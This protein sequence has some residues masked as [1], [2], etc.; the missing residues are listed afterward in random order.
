MRVLISCAVAS[1]LGSVTAPSKLAAPAKEV[2]VATDVNVEISG[3]SGLTV[4]KDGDSVS[5][6][7]TDCKDAA[8]GVMAPELTGSKT[9][10]KAT[11]K[12]SKMGTYKVCYKLK[13][14]AEYTAVDGAS[15]VVGNQW[16]SKKVVHMTCSNDFEDAPNKSEM[17]CKGKCDAEDHVT[18]CKAKHP[19]LC[20]TMICPSGMHQNPDAAKKQCKTLPCAPDLKEDQD[21]CCAKNQMCKDVCTGDFVTAE[22]KEKVSCLGAKCSDEEKKT[23][24][25]KKAACTKDICPAKSTLKPKAGTCAGA[26]CTEKADA[27]TCCTV[28]ATCSKDACG[29]G[30]VLKTDKSLKC[31]ADKCTTA[32]DQATCC[33]KQAVCSVDVCGDKT[34]IKK[35]AV[36][37]GATCDK[38]KDKAACC[39]A[40]A[41]C[42]AS[43]CA[44]DKVL[45]AKAMCKGLKCD[46]AVDAGTCCAA[47]A[48]CSTVK[49]LT[50]QKPA[51]ALCK[52]EK[53]VNADFKI[54]CPLTTNTCGTFIC[55]VNLVQDPAKKAVTCEG[56]ECLAP[57]D[58]AK[59]CKA[60]PH[61]SNKALTQTAK[62]LNS[63][64]LA[65]AFS[66][67]L[68]PLLT[69]AVKV[70]SQKS[71]PAKSMAGDIAL[72]F[73]GG[74]AKQFATALARHPNAVTSAM[75][76][77][78]ADVAGCDDDDIVLS[79]LK[80]AADA[81]RLLDERRLTPDQNLHFCMRGCPT[82]LPPTWVPLVCFLAGG[83]IAAVLA[84]IAFAGEDSGKGNEG[85]RSMPLTQSTQMQQ[86][87]PAGQ[88]YTTSGQP[89][90]TS[91]QTYTVVGQ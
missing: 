51:D 23:C 53:C 50:G 65:A 36:C 27:E 4:G 74:D 89:Y 62:S 33:D 31:K 32:T 38:A 35:D 28:P 9:T 30:F 77:A 57:R 5:F 64:S 91:G 18:C 42:E 12:F 90:V 3:G 41:K 81:R 34:L 2:E 8:K 61:P 72:D 40:P 71:D 44:K 85:A 21:T 10:A 66:K 47:K 43:L 29:T 60:A 70:V 84:L 11:V 25:A 75:K 7:T 87:A 19:A 49:C 76:M 14:K 86:Y 73:E 17:Q 63:A 16:C 45:K 15:I 69:G 48:K 88:T 39:S 52:G 79:G 55:G 80:P 82:I 83:V 59:C 37:A 58:D 6:V 24:C 78:I 68:N 26:K 54:C 13:E 22:G 67:R 46:K 20:N 56:T 1:A